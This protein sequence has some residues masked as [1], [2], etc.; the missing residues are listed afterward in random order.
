LNLHQGLAAAAHLPPSPRQSPK[1]VA[2]RL[3]VPSQDPVPVHTYVERR[4]ARQS[5]RRL[6]S[7]PQD[8]PDLQPISPASS[9][10]S[11]DSSSIGPYTPESMDTSPALP[12][13]SASKP[14]PTR[15]VL[16]LDA[17]HLQSRT[18]DIIRRFPHIPRMHT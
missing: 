7:P 11:S 15:K 10:S 3:S 2:M 1:S 8:V 6:R 5:H 14:L 9:S 12:P 16:G 17:S 4:H 18:R 13:K